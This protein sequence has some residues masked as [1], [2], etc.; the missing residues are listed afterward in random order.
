MK[1]L[2]LAVYSLLLALA[3]PEKRVSVTSPENLESMKA[4]YQSIAE[5]VVAVSEAE[6]AFTGADAVGRTAAIL[7][8]ISYM[9]SGFRYDVDRGKCWKGSCDE[10]K[11]KA[12]SFCLA[13]IHIGEG[14]TQ[15][16]WTGADLIADRKKCYTTALHLIKQSIGACGNLS[17]YTLGTCT[18]NEPKAVARWNKY[19]SVYNQLSAI[20][21][22]QAA[23][24]P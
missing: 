24:T 16:G 5:D 14:K 11:G 20:R 2:V 9:E 22:A 18:A 8:A 15:E 17:G 23:Q 1:T 6:Q 3:P 12:T 21:K 4:R 7:V 13:Q 10:Y 19:A